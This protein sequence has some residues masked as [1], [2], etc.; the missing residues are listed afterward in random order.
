MERNAIMRFQ[1][2]FHR[3][4]VKSSIALI[5]ICLVIEKRKSCLKLGIVKIARFHSMRILD[6]QIS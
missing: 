2:T 4:A 6:L 5:A 1:L 3:Q